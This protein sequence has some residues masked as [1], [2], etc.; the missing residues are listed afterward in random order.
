V[1]T[2]AVALG[3]GGI[4]AVA[5]ATGM[6]R[7][8]IRAGIRKV[9]EL[10]AKP[11]VAEKGKDSRIRRPGGGRKA[12]AHHNPGWIEALEALVEPLTQR[13]CSMNIIANTERPYAAIFNSTTRME[14]IANDGDPAGKPHRL[15][16][17]P[18][19]QYPSQNLC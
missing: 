5:K 15:A 9:K 11:S 16:N 2:E 1:A 8:T 14:T 6:S 13:F 7:T 4:S 19:H 12:L 10:G 17:K 3:R 18:S